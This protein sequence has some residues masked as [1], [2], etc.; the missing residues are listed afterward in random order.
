MHKNEYLKPFCQIL[1]NATAIGKVEM[2]NLHACNV[3]I[4]LI[5]V[6]L[7]KVFTNFMKFIC[8]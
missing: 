1:E 7:K 2:R 4:C 5:T 3:L 8:S 6:L